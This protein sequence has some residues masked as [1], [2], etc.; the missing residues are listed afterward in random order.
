[1]QAAQAQYKKGYDRDKKTQPLQYGVGDWIPVIRQTPPIS[2]HSLLGGGGL[3][4][5]KM[6]F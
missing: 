1:M 3:A 5:A 4:I 2:A 6:T